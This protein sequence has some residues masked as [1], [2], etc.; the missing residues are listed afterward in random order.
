MADFAESRFFPENGGTN[1]NTRAIPRTAFLAAAIT[2]APAGTDAAAKTIAVDGVTCKLADAIRSANEASAFGGCAVGDAGADAI[3]LTADAV[4]VGELPAVVSNV[5]FNGGGHNITG[6]YAHRLFFIGGQG[7]PPF[8]SFANVSLVGGSARGGTGRTGGGGG[9]GL[10]GAVFI[11]DGNVEFESVSF[12]SNNA[13]G[14]AANGQPGA[15]C[16]YLVSGGGGGGGM[17]GNGGYAGTDLSNFTGNNGGGGGF[18]GGGGGGG[19]AVSNGEG[20]GSGGKGGGAFGGGGGNGG[21]QS[22]SG[23]EG[24][25]GSGGGGGGD[26]RSGGYGGF[27]GGGGGGGGNIIQYAGGNGASGGFGGGGGASGYALGGFTG[28]YGGFGGG[29]GASSSFGVP[30]LGGFGA[31]SAEPQGSGGGGAGLGGAVF[32]RAGSVLL[33]NANFS[34][35]S[36]S[37]GVSDSSSPSAGKAGAV[38]AIA[39][40]QNENGNV[41]GMPLSRPTVTGCANAFDENFASEAGT[42][43]ADNADV[44]GVDRL[45]LAL[46]CGE[47]IFHDGLEAR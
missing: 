11:F 24:G 29:G 4:V 33:H 13:I 23:A 39:T 14:G 36:A 38:F 25:F 22:A 21:T 2:L 8:V 46:P 6:D 15:C 3:V 45:D 35:N 28:G 32:V 10:G 40:L 1:V 18:G 31:G 12:A 37:G 7:D 26:N 20:G 34:S 16:G 42:S 30:G 5:A 44:F 27:G 9:G 17:A 47:R 41:A 43:P 19:A